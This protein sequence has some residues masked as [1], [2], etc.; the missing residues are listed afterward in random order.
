MA[1]RSR[2]IMIM[3]AL[4]MLSMPI[5]GREN[6]S[7]YWNNKGKELAISGQY[8]EAVRAFDK[9]IRLKQD[10]PDAWNNKGAALNRLGLTTEAILAFAKAKEL[11]SPRLGESYV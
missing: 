3:I 7:S 8:D 4:S 2:F 1:V 10:Y 9:S 5:L 6:S 11:E